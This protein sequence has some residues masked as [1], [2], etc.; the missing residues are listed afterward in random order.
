[1]EEEF[2]VLEI[3]PNHVTLIPVDPNHSSILEELLKE[4]E[5]ESISVCR[6]VI[7]D[8]SEHGII[9]PARIVDNGKFISF[10][11][12]EQLCIFNPT[13]SYILK[14]E[15]LIETQLLTTALMTCKINLEGLLEPEEQFDESESDPKMEAPAK[16][17]SG[18]G[19]EEE[20]SDPVLDAVLEAIAPLPKPQPKKTKVEDIFQQL[21]EEFVRNALWKPPQQTVTA[22]APVVKEPEPLQLSQAQ[23]AIK[24]KMKSLLRGMLS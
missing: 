18:L 15:V 21:D 1:M 7:Q 2:S 17:S 13:Q 8:S 22:P 3:I 11:L 5:E 4:N 24:E 16:A 9:L 23:L 12:P 14:A 20:Y 19:G 10:I 6:V